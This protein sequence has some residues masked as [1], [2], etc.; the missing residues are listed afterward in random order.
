LHAAF[1]TILEGPAQGEQGLDPARL[2]L[3][4]TGP[5]GDRL[6]DPAKGAL[7]HPEVVVRHG[8]FGFEG[9][10]RGVGLYRRFALPKD[11][12]GERVS[13]EFKNGVLTISVPK[14]EEVRPREIEVRIA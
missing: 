6:A 2:A 8:V 12:D 1:V 4:E 10:G 13:A 5:E 9:G 3:Y 14:R 7:R 11:A